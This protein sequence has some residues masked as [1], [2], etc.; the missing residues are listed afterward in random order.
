MAGV[1]DQ[2]VR[3][4]CPRG[5]CRRRTS[6]HAGV[7]VWA[8][9]SVATFAQLPESAEKFTS[10]DVGQAKELVRRNVRL[11]DLNGVTT[12]SYDAAV[13]LKRSD[14]ETYDHIWLLLDG[15]TSLS[16]QVAKVLCEGEW[17]RLSLNG[18]TTI[19]PET[20]KALAARLGGR[21]LCLNGLKSLSPEVAK[22]LGECVDVELN[23][24]QEVSDSVGIALT[25][26]ATSTIRLNGLT[27]LPARAAR[28]WVSHQ[29]EHTGGGEIFLNG[30]T[31]LPSDLAAAL[32]PQ[33]GA[34]FLDGVTT[35]P[36]NVAKALSPEDEK[37][38]HSLSLNGLRAISPE[39][40]AHLGQS[41]GSLSLNG[42]TSLSPEVA[43]A[44]A[45]GKR[46]SPLYLNGLSEISVE[47]ADALGGHQGELVLNGLTVISEDVAKA[48]SRH[49]GDLVLNGLRTMTP[50][51][52]K[53]L[54]SN[55]KVEMPPR[56]RR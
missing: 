25:E 52:A 56:F 20:A 33:I 28:A 5:G 24:V 36:P 50:E 17:D 13:A 22:E 6:F 37:D 7:V 51:A 19:S 4:D 21:R 8:G 49:S 26:A 46:R 53:A 44:L 43:V 27:S 2:D 31:E 54:Q 34:L 47:A 39:S 55:P 30:L 11:L 41:Y 45:R 48:L 14:D 12:L 23:G 32:G 38:S 3:F 18:L 42:L 10:L 15:L 1:T 35:L 40:A 9:L 16:P 29:R